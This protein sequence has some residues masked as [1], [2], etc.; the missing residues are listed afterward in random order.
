MALANT[1]ILLIEDNLALAEN[2]IEIL[3]IEG[4]DVIHVTTGARAREVAVQG[5]DVAL[6]DVTL[7]DST[8]LELLRELKAGDDLREVLLVTGNASVED[9]I[10]AVKGGAYDYIV[11]PFQVDE[12]LSS[13]ERACRQVRASR[14]T[15][16][17]ADE[18]AHREKKLRTLVDTVQA[19]LLELDEHGRVLQANPAVAEVTGASPEQLEGMEWMPNFVPDS[20]RDGTEYVFAR[21][22]AG[23]SRIA[24]E[25]PIISLDGT[26]ERTISWMSSALEQP[27]GSL[28]VYASGLDVTEFKDL[29]R[30]TRLAERLAAVGTMS[31]G[32]AHEI[33]NPLNSAQLQLRLLERRLHK[34]AVDTKLMRPIE[35]VQS[36]LQR[37]SS[38]VHEFLD[39]ARPSEP[40][41]SDTELSEIVEHVMALESPRALEHGVTIELRTCEPVRVVADPGKIKQVL[42]NLVRNAVEAMPD[43]GVAILELEARDDGAL[44]RV[45]DSGPG[46]PDDVL[47]RI[48]E[49]FYSTKSEGT[50]LGMAICHS[51]VTQ[52][53]GDVRVLTGEQGTTVEVWLPSHPLSEAAIVP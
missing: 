6:V 29:E 24:H 32:L 46:L 19:L 17:L 26:R 47:E 15:R 3:E 41:L 40:K 23:E 31:A 51:L 30:R 45:I 4:S 36:E 44:L 28:H 1:R 16:K 21:I 35:L 14:S 12:L 38:L 9:A 39:F 52:H 50:G 42:L 33:R 22:L 10:E 37:L 27:D 11:K 48:F 8:G 53:G 5:F 49:P 25:N 2:V 7:P 18:V 34:H 20:A 13:V 43:G